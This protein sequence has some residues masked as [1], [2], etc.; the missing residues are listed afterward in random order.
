MTSLTSSVSSSSSLGKRKA[1]DDSLSLQPKKRPKGQTAEEW[2]ASF[3]KHTPYVL[4]LGHFGQK[5]PIEILG[6]EGDKDNE[7]VICASLVKDALMGIAREARSLMNTCHPSV[8]KFVAESCTQLA[9]NADRNNTTYRQQRDKLNFGWMKIEERVEQC[10][11]ALSSGNASSNEQVQF[12]IEALS[13]EVEVIDALINDA[14]K[15]LRVHCDLINQQMASAS[16]SLKK[17]VVEVQSFNDK[18]S[19]DLVFYNIFADNV[20]SVP[21]TNSVTDQANMQAVQKFYKA[22]YKAIQIYEVYLHRLH[23]RAVHAREIYQAGL[24]ALKV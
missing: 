16:Q 14:K 2:A 1:P 11:E 20:F 18:A 19:K 17:R 22:Y 9:M 4:K 5:S 10:Q 21:K 3:S 12:L 6:K 13:H 23:L 8:I 15:G 24:K 7:V